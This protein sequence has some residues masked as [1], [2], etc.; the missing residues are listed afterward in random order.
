MTLTPAE[1]KLRATA[2][3]HMSWTNTPDPP[4]RTAKAR[5]AFAKSF[6]D[7]V[8]PEHKLDPAERARRAESARK[9]HFAQL[10]L[11]SAKARRN[12]AGSKGK[13]A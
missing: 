7:K 6:E 2:A 13:A 9:A 8:D 12:R 3:A 11:A 5:D 10:A 4:A 1:R